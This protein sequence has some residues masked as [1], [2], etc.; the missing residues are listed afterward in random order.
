L[1]IESTENAFS[2]IPVK[3]GIQSFTGIFRILDTR[4][5]GYDEL[6]KTLKERKQHNRHT[7][8]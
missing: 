8:S 4:V 6:Y 2:V 7:C 1:I 3:T 5:R